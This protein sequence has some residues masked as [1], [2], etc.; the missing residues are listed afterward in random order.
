M[1]YCG[2]TEVPE[3]SQTTLWFMRTAL[4]IILAKETP[5]EYVIFIAFHLKIWL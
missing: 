1:K 2:N 5:S 4:W 3:R